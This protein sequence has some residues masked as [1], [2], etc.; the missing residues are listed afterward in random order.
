MPT[1]QT[2]RCIVLN[3]IVPVLARKLYF[4]SKFWI[5]YHGRQLFE[6]HC[7]TVYAYFL[8]NES[9]SCEPNKHLFLPRT[10]WA[11]HFVLLEKS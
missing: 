8:T 9:E 7:S 1:Q 11:R 10:F 4:S 2:F 6:F 3:A 5:N